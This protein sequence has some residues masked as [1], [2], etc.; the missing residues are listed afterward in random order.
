[1][2]FVGDC[3]FSIR[4]TATKNLK[5]LTDVFGTE[6]FKTHILPKITELTKHTNYLYR[7][8]TLFAISTLAPSLGPDLTANCLLPITLELVGD[9]IANIKLNVAKT[10][11]ALVT[12]VDSSVVETKIKPALNKLLEDK[13][14]DVRYFAS[15]ALQSC[16]Q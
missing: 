1:M 12:V 14:R 4:E 6:W 7:I 11:Q 13:D 9:R 16:N 2:T 10:M 8:T 3:V 5:K 15:L